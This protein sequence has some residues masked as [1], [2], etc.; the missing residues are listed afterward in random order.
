[1]TRKGRLE[2][3]APRAAPRPVGPAARGRTVPWGHGPRVLWTTSGGVTAPLGTRSKLDGTPPG[4]PIGC[5]HQ[6]LF[7]RATG[8]HL[9]LGLI[10]R[11]VGHVDA[12]LS[13]ALG[14]SAPSRLRGP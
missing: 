4:P 7:K 2:L 5:P 9:R 11:L 6:H 3:T 8:F 14:D 12:G 13:D 10:S 1:M